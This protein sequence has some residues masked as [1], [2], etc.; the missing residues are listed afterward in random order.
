MKTF[1]YPSLKVSG[2][3]EAIDKFLEL[4]YTIWKKD[5]HGYQ[6]EFIQVITGLSYL[7]DEIIEFHKIVLKQPNYSST[8][9]GVIHEQWLV[10]KYR[11][12]SVTHF[13][14]RCHEGV[15][16]DAEWAESKII[17]KSLNYLEIAY[18][19]YDNIN[20]SLWWCFIKSAYP[21]L[22]FTFSELELQY[23][24]C[25]Y[26]Q[27]VIYSHGPEVED[28]NPDGFDLSEHNVDCAF[29]EWNPDGFVYEADPA[30]DDG[31]CLDDFLLSDLDLI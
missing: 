10:G 1:N 7:P 9:I 17:F 27:R 21:E 28:H 5:S 15:F 12:S 14:D 23:P 11:N 3:T 19:F 8:I 22:Y 25:Y 30:F 4:E 20:P 26:K 13:S 16:Y 29:V 6:W 2:P 31:E 18:V 24:I